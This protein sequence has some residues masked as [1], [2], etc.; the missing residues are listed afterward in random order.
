MYLRMWECLSFY[1]MID[2]RTSKLDARGIK[3]IF[4]GYDENS[5]EYRLLNLDSNVI[6]ESRDVEFIEKKTLF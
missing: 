6:L 4:V 5:K 2:P 1:R 3:S